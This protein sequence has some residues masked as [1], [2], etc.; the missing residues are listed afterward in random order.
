MKRKTLQESLTVSNEV[1]QISSEIKNE[2]LMRL[3]EDSIVMSKEF[4]KVL[5]KASLLII[6]KASYQ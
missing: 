2:L 4:T 6:Q 3:S 5:K 1:K